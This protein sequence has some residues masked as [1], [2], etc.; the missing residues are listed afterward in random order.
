MKSVTVVGLG[1]VGLPLACLCAENDLDIYGI[2]IDSN[3]VKLINQ[4]IS[5]IDDP[6]LIEKVKKAS[7]LLANIT[8]KEGL[9]SD[10]GIMNDGDTNGVLDTDKHWWPQ[11]EAMVGFLNAFQISNEKKFFESSYNCWNFVKNH[12]VDKKNG[13][14]FFRVN[15]KGKPYL[16]VEDKVGPWKAPYH[17]TRACLEIMKRLKRLNSTS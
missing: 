6:E 14:W 8:L 7:L 11:A 10:G 16:L 4:G 3:K 1:Y 15:R 2:D 17:N 9:D 5:P 12:I 13:E